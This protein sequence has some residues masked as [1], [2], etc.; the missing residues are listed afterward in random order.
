[1]QHEY[2][3]T[4]RSSIKQLKKT[5][6]AKLESINVP[7]PE[8]WQVRDSLKQRAVQYTRESTQSRERQKEWERE[9]EREKVQTK[10]RA[11]MERI[12]KDRNHN[13]RKMFIK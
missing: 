7:V 11:L 9:K 6:K 3:S 2:T 10:T 5:T 8:V 12:I 1:L 4:L 13:A